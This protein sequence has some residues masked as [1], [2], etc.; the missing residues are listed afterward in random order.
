[1]R[2]LK[3]IRSFVAVFEEGSF[4]AAALREGAT[5]SGI[6]QHIRHLEESLGAELLVRDGR[7]VIP[8]VH[9]ERY[10]GE[11]VAILRRLDL[12]EAEISRSSALGG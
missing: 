4:T 2:S 5:Q 8:T 9:G 11:C 10:Y 3:Q 1:M 6:S 12:A 7:G